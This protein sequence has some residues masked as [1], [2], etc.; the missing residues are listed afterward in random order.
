[1]TVLYDA[2]CGACRWCADRLR[3][4]D[5]HQVLRFEPIG[6]T[7]GDRLLHAVPVERRLDS[8]HVVERDGRVWSAGQAVARILRLLPWGRPLALAAELAPGVTDGLYAAAA[9]H[10]STLGRLLGRRACAVDPSRETRGPA[11]RP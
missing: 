2:D 9:R 7:H 10:R 6:T 8:W 3:A 5:R 4:W 11:P 1:M